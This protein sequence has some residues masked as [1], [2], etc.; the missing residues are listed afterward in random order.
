MRHISGRAS[1]ARA[2]AAPP[3]RQRKQQQQ[4]QR[5][6]AASASS[7]AAAAAAL[8]RG[9][10][11]CAGRRALL[12]PA[13]NRPSLP[14]NPQRREGSS[15]AC[16]RAAQGQAVWLLSS[17][18]EPRKP[19]SLHKPAQ[20][21]PGQAHAYR[22]GGGGGGLGMAQ[23]PLRAAVAPTHRAQ[24]RPTFVS[25]GNSFLPSVSSM[26]QPTDL[27]PRPGWAGSGAEA[28]WVCAAQ[29]TAMQAP[30]ATPAATHRRCSSGS[31]VPRH[32]ARPAATPATAAPE[33]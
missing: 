6:A 3:P 10:T 8:A 33:G 22:E 20:A 15:P 17:S 9:L 28:G 5:C 29:P 11:G 21:G 4:Q 18:W 13:R 24:M 25:T 16:R 27:R 30:A 2:R 1:T 26:M 12:A 19:Q 32:Q 23:A 14:Q 7:A 31:C